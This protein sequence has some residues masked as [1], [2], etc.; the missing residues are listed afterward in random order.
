[1]TQADLKANLLSK[2]IKEIS[3]QEGFFY[4]G[5]ATADELTEE[6]HKL[7]AWLRK[8]HQ[9]KMSYM[10]R[11]FDKRIDPRK[12]VQGARSVISLLLNY[13]PGKIR[14]TDGAPLI[15]KY[16]Y[17]EDYHFVIKRKLKTLITL[18]KDEFGEFNAR[19]FV[20]SAP[21]MDKAWAHKAGLGWQGK[22]SNL[23]NKKE[24]SFFFI[25]EIISDLVLEPDN[26]SGDFCGT[27]TRCIDACP[28]EAIVEPYVVDANKC[29]SY[30][31]I[32]LKDA[33]KSEWKEKLNNWVFGCDICQDVCPW[34]RFSKQHLE[35]SFT[36]DPRLLNFSKEEWNE[37]TEELFNDMFKHSA[38]QRT[39]FKRLKENIHLLQSKPST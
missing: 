37:I 6:A 14:Q 10:E 3:S 31:T 13:Y 33:L 36:P 7:E 18:M 16:A 5:I 29:I 26:P 39:G 21:V 30:L 24:G 28:T 19:V 9:G 17:G 35:S 22:H 8:G 32:E 1:V 2:R 15:S 20:D 27:C 4:T 23:I 38:I 25:A 12:L 11:N 34:N